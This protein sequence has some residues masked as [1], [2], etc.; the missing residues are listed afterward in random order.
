MAQNKEITLNSITR[1]WRF[2]V[3]TV[4]LFASLSFFASTMI[5]PEYKSQ[6]EILILQKNLDIDPYRAAKASEYAGEV[7]EGVSGSSDFMNGILE[8]IGSNAG[9][10]GENPEKQMEN[11]KKAVSV[12]PLVNTGIVKIT[13]LD[14]NKRENRKLMEG[15]MAE[16]Q[17]NGV[18]YHGNENIT[19]KKIGG[20]VYFENPAYPV[21][22]LNV[23]VAGAVGLFASIGMILLFGQNLGSWFTNRS[24]IKF[25]NGNLNQA[26]YHYPE[27]R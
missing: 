11:W 15:V 26:F 9:K 12:T 3:I 13:V 21:I 22:W 27:V 7:L 20:P 24:K 18:A 5:T 4:M 6:A 1:N 23:L 17:E 19:L 8:K 25:Q 2:I 14:P 10:F 16:L